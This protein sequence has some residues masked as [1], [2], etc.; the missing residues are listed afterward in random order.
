VILVNPAVMRAL[1]KPVT[2]RAP[3]PTLVSSGCAARP[4]LPIWGKWVLSTPNRLR[5]A[6]EHAD[7][8]GE[9]ARG[10]G[11]GE[12]TPAG[13]RAVT[14]VVWP[15]LPSRGCEDHRAL[16]GLGRWM[17]CLRGCGEPRHPLYAWRAS[18]AVNEQN[19]TGVAVSTN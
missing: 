14:I 6:R 13:C 15:A 8:T 19:R 10:R 18:A 4:P 2:V 5:I 12:M 16:K 9:L 17:P 7:G 3:I 11:S 1:V